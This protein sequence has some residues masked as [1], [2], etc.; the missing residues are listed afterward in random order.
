MAF[1]D[2]PMFDAI[3]NG[4]GEKGVLKYF[5]DML[6]GANTD[7]MV[8]S[9][10]ISGYTLIFMIPPNLSSEDYKGIQEGLKDTSKMFA[11]LALDFTPPPVQVVSTSLPIR[12]GSLSYATEVNMSGQ[13]TITFLD[14]DELE[15]FEFHKVWISYIEAVTR[16]TISPHGDYFDPETDRFG[17]VDYVTS[18]YV[19]RFKITGDIVYVGKATGIFPLNLPDKEVIGRRDSNELTILPINYSCV[20]YRQQ[21][22]GK[23]SK[24]ENWILD[25]LEK[26]LKIYP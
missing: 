2:S 16:G 1:D 18:A 26:L 20:L 17:I 8:F 14:T 11:L 9:P 10:D 24:S 7:D 23:L 3:K 19:V 12:A 15:C 25:E 13:I 4:L 22:K 5:D 6:M 21:V